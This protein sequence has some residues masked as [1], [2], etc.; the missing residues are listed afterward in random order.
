MFGRRKVFRS[1]LA[2]L[3]AAVL[4]VGIA[5]APPAAGQTSPAPALYHEL[6]RPQFHFTPARNWM[7]D[8][9]GLLYTDL[10]MTP[11]AEEEADALELFTQ[12]KAA[13]D[14]VDHA[15]KVKK[16]THSAA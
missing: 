9:N 5:T 11:V 12:N 14:A 10:A 7:N 2:I 4:A 13:R 1:M 6:Y 3:S 15:R 8:P 16:L